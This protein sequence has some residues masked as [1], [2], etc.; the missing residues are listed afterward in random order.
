M[1]KKE[2]DE[3]ILKSDKYGRQTKKVQLMQDRPL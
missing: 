2:T 3:K 1:N